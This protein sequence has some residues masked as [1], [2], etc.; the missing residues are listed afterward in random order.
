MTKVLVGIPTYNGYYRVDWLLQSIQMRTDKNIDYKIIV[1][2]DSGRKEHQDKTISVVNR[3][4]N[5]INVDILINNSNIGLASSWNRIVRSNE[6]E[7]VILI[8]DDIIVAKDWLETM[9]YFLDNNPKAGS[10]SHFCY[11]IIKEDV[12]AL[13]SK[14]DAIVIPRDPFTK[15]QTEKYND[16]LEYPGRVMAPAGCFFGFRR[17]IYNEI[18]GFDEHYYTFYE[19]SDFG[20]TLAS[21]GY[22]TYCLSYPKNWHIWSATFGEAPEIN[23]GQIMQK[24]REYYIRKW[25][26]HFEQTH[27]RYMSKIPFQKVGF[28]YKGQKYEKIIDAEHGYYVNDNDKANVNT[29]IKIK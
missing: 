27:P 21:R 22:P 3:W 17:D 24:S 15:A 29:L 23:A 7:H 4:K 19:E 20:T 26:G 18:G 9:T 1:C 6:S 16:M 2:D 28:M 12:P 8:N 14:N 5:E 25:N 10:V 11:F 13:L